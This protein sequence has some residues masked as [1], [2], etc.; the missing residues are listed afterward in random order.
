MPAYYLL[1]NI[2]F[3]LSSPYSTSPV[4][5]GVLQKVNEK[6]ERFLKQ[7]FPHFSILYHTLRK[8]KNNPMLWKNLWLDIQVWELHFNKTG[9]CP[10][11]EFLTDCSLLQWNLKKR[12]ESLNTSWFDLIM[13]QG[14]HYYKHY[15]PYWSYYV[16]HLKYS[17]IWLFIQNDKH[18]SS[19]F[20]TMAVIMSF[21][22]WMVSEFYHYRKKKWKIENVN[23]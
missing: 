3:P 13:I 23:G 2:F 10:A 16:S 18:Y 7:R 22:L 12:L 1:M 5:L 8:G 6:C 21:Y 19:C 15:I 17:I 20:C 14:P 9:L 4:R 11:S